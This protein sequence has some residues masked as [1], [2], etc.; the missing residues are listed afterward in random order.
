MKTK[1][2]CPIILIFCLVTVLSASP[3]VPLAWQT[4]VKSGPLAGQ[5]KHVDWI[6]DQN[7][8]FIDDA[9][10]ELARDEMT[11]VIVQLSE[12]LCP[13]DL[14]A[15]FGIYGR[16]VSSGVLVAYVILDDVP[17]YLLDDLA[18][19]P[20][21]AGVE[22]PL[23]ME[24]GLNISTRTVRARKSYTYSPGTFFDM[25]VGK[26]KGIKVAIVDTGVDDS[27]GAFQNKLAGGFNALDWSDKDNN[28]I[29]D[30]CEGGDLG[31]CEPGDGTTNPDDDIGHGT[32][33]ASIAVG[34]GA[35]KPGIWESGRTPS[36]GTS[37]TLNDGQGMTPDAKYLDVK[38][39]EL[40]PQTNEKKFEFNW[41]TEGLEWIFRNGEANV[42]NFSIWMKNS[43]KKGDG[44]VSQLINGLVAHGI[45]VVTISGNAGQN[46]L[47]P[48]AAAE[49]AITVGNVDDKWSVDR[50]DDEI[51]PTSNYGPR[52]DFNEWL[53]KKDL[54]ELKVGMLNPDIVAPGT[55]I[56]SAKRGTTD[57]Y[58]VA[59]GTS[60]SA[61]HVAGAIALLLSMP[62]GKDLPPESMKELLKETA[63]YPS[64]VKP[65]YPNIPIPDYNVKW[66]YGM[67]DVHAAAQALK[68][69]FTDMTFPTALKGTKE[70][71]KHPGW[72]DVRRCLLQ[73]KS[74]YANNID[75]VVS[76]D[77]P[78]Q[79]KENYITV[80]VENRPKVTDPKAATNVKVCVGV[81][82]FKVG[83]HQMYNVGCKTIASIGPGASKSV[84]FPWKATKSE[85]QCI[86]A[87]I[88]YPFDTDFTNNVT[89]R[90]VK[91]K[92][93]SSPSRGVF[94]VDNP[95][96]E[97]ATIALEVKPDAMALRAYTYELEQDTFYL[98]PEDCPV[99]N[100]IHF[101]PKGPQSVG[102]T[103]IFDIAGTAFSESNEDGIELSGVVFKV[104]TV[105]PGLERVYTSASHGPE[106]MIDLPLALSGSPTSDP[107][108]QV[109]LVRVFFN[110]PVRPLRGISLTEAV[111]NS[112]TSDSN[113][114][115]PD[116]H[117]SFE[118][119][120]DAGTDLTIE[121]FEPLANGDLYT[122]DFGRPEGFVDLDGDPLTGDGDFE[123][124]IRYG[125]ADDDGALAL[126]DVS[127]V[128]DRI[129][130]A[131][132]FGSTCR[133]DLNQ[134]GVITSE[135]IHLVI[136]RLPD[137][138]QFDDFA[139]F[140]E[141]W[142]H[143]GMELAGDLDGDHDVDLEDLMQFAGYWLDYSPAD[144]PLE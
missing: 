141:Q 123:L 97:P 121:F 112:I 134:D 6:C 43:H 40:D 136:D 13:E 144:W 51:N 126:D 54:N 101:Y 34:L 39:G 61:P 41:I 65:S 104:V 33:M 87:S 84:T 120:A 24:T 66:G 44:P 72:P 85:H 122:F 2:T 56:Y 83:A 28:G 59:S 96:N 106:G 135:D 125:D 103:A 10:D 91:V 81:I 7:G 22:R 30:S 57:K 140:G 77:P 27:H 11:Q 133:A 26:G 138:V 32:S 107:R 8:D 5:Y 69:G 50:S 9:F 67:L 137:I 48:G 100:T 73:G 29:D 23:P 53:K 52:F 108:W 16:V 47:G 70:V 89:Q 37:T 15:V 95:L 31:I 21:V 36:D 94:Y 105:D 45:H 129:G 58:D 63:S 79:D 117:A 113:N 19:E 131:V 1:A 4:R 90:N 14:N 92:Y 143:G 139:R 12:C 118:E 42:V 130:Q 142:L 93:N 111:R 20:I 71:A 78:L 119:Q 88:A 82:D 64:N 38:V 3:F 60:L 25:G 127:F 86:Q 115:V 114:L 17:V 124:L 80:T 75:I 110:V 68:K 74:S 35:G 98:R 109:N 46:M 55:D 132:E 76:P 18:S 62:E 128:H 99:L 102:Q 116:F 49:L